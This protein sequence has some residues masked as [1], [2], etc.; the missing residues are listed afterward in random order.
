MSLSPLGFAINLE[1]EPVSL[2]NELS[3]CREP[4]LSVLLSIEYCLQNKSISSLHDTNLTSEDMVV[5]V[6]V[7]VVIVNCY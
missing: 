3:L 2:S 1:L 6:V 5:V 7:V 4:V